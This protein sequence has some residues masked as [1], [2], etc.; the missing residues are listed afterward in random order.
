MIRTRGRLVVACLALIGAATIAVAGGSAGNE[1]RNGDGKLFAL[2]GPGAVTYGENI[3]YRT[4]F[5]NA[6]ANSGSVFTQT[7]LVLN[8]PT[9]PGVSVTGVISSCGNTF[10]PV[11]QVLTCEFGQLRPG[12][13]PIEVTV[14]WNV[15]AVDPNAAPGCPD[16]LV[17]EG[18]WLIKEGKPT[19]SNE[20]F[21]VKA[22]A[23]LLGAN[24]NPELSARFHAGGYELNGCVTSGA[25]NL[26]TSPS[27]NSTDPIQSSFCLPASFHPTTATGGV[28][29][30]ITEPSTGP[31]FARHSDI[32]IADPGQICP[33]GLAATF[34]DEITFTFKVA[35]AAL[36]SGYKIT[37]VSHNEHVL[38][39]CGTMAAATSTE[40]CVASIAPPK[41]NPKI[42]TIVA[43]AQTNGSWDW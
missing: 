6:N 18:T 43:R 9:A 4:T 8:P 29:S 20:S 31:G 38:P 14:V 21:P 34:D 17:A 10:D 3:A 2:P 27:I 23:A 32:C 12:D 16:C 36:P 26:T 28:A 30:T 22:T 24:S 40:G 11:T 35:D 15:A 1:N 42:W 37:Q 7:K 25:T 41:G 5:T 33:D 13:P 19:N 39:K